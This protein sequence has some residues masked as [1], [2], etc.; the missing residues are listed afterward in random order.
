M[1]NTESAA[2]KAWTREAWARAFVRAV[3]IVASNAGVKPGAPI[4]IDQRTGN[5]LASGK[6]VGRV[7]RVEDGFEVEND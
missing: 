2:V 7:I 4:R 3:T 5:V 6:V 1:T